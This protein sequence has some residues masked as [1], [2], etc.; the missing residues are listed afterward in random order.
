MFYDLML[1]PNG[2]RPMSGAWPTAQSCRSHGYYV[3]SIRADNWAEAFM[4]ALCV[5][6]R[7]PEPAAA[8]LV[9]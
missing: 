9:A 7:H 1:T 8:A 3:V 6:V 4:K 2:P 5:E